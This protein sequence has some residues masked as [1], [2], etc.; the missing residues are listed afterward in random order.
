MIKAFNNHLTNID[1]NKAWDVLCRNYKALSNMS[2]KNSAAYKIRSGWWSKEVAVNMA[3]E[4]LDSLKQYIED[5]AQTY[6]NCAAGEYVIIPG[7][8]KL[9]RGC[10]ENYY[11]VEKPKGEPAYG[12]GYWISKDRYLDNLFNKLE[13]AIEKIEN[14]TDD[15]AL[16][17]AV[18][19]YNDIRLKPNNDMYTCTDFD[20]AYKGDGVY[21]AMMTMVKYLNLRFDDD[22]GNEMSRDE[23]IID[24]AKNVFDSK[25]D[26][27]TMLKYCQKKAFNGKFDWK[28]YYR[29]HL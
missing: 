26:A 10:R 29:N 15:K 4:D 23:C 16:Y 27:N 20:N 12:W 9:D 18:K 21:S 17:E 2:D 19:K 14:A 6:D 5:N 3:N 7:L 13:S 22:K 28:D 8:T 25:F 24:I 11:F 1:Y